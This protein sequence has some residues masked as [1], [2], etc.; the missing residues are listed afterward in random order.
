MAGKF[1]VND[2]GEA[3]PCR[4]ITEKCP[5]GGESGVEHHFDSIEMARADYERR[6]SDGSLPGA[7][8]K[9]SDTSSMA[10]LRM[11]MEENQYGSAIAAK[12]AIDRI[13]FSKSA[14][15]A[16]F[17]KYE[18]T[19]DVSFNVAF[20]HDEDEAAEFIE[21]EMADIGYSVITDPKEKDFVIGFLRT[22]AGRNAKDARNAKAAAN[23]Q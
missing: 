11:E 5:F 23:R 8:K 4:A 14:V 1:H 10:Q 16:I 22:W 15:K 17:S 13:G 3:G 20:A 6:M 18:E 7:M 12:R 2:K 19:G 9:S 21:D